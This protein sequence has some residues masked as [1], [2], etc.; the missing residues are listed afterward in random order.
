MSNSLC[1][2]CNPPMT[3]KQR[4]HEESRPY[5]IKWMK[6]MEKRDKNE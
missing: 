6:E 5:Y 2:K 4:E 3:K 1:K